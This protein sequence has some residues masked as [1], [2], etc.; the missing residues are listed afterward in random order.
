MINKI[1]SELE[2]LSKLDGLIVTLFV[3][4]QNIGLIKMPYNKR[5]LSDWFPLR[6]KPAANASVI[7]ER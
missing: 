4:L 1:E 3:S 2:W 7:H 6:S 5:M